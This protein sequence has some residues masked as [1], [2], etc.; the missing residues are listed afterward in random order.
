[1]HTVA[2]I[3]TRPQCTR[4][5]DLLSFRKQQFLANPTS[6]IF[7]HSKHGAVNEGVGSSDKSVPKH[8][9][10]VGLQTSQGVFAPLHRAAFHPVIH[11]S[12]QAVLHPSKQLLL[13]CSSSTRSQHMVNQSKYYLPLC[14]IPTMPSIAFQPPFQTSKSSPLQ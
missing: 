9:K 13:G 1:M 5:D 3:L 2:L 11:P 6:M 10:T 7:L 4:R 12:L 8:M 14:P